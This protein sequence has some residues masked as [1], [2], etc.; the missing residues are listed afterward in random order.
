MYLIAY[1][2]L[3][4]QGT[5]GRITKQL[6]LQQLDAFHV[7]SRLM[8]IPLGPCAVR[9]LAQALAARSEGASH[10]TTLPEDLISY[11]DENGNVRYGVFEPLPLNDDTINRP[12]RDQQ[13]V[14]NSLLRASCSSDIAL[15]SE[16]FCTDVLRGSTASTAI[17]P[18]C[19]CRSVEGANCIRCC[20]RFGQGR[21]DKIY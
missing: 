1:L 9:P 7:L 6:I 11:Y 15:L 2:A 19:K 12:E 5:H 8:C 10:R 4:K 18:P 17:A 3:K 20:Q 14:L 16:T 13:P 21:H